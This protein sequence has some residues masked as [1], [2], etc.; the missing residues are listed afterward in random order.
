MKTGTVPRI[1][2]NTIDY[3]EL[4]AQ[5]SDDPPAHFSFSSS[6]RYT[7]PQLPCHITYT[8]EHT[9]EIIRQGID[10]SPLY[11]GIIEGIGARYCPSIEDKV[12]RF[13]EKTRHQI[14]LEP[15]GLDTTEVYPNGIPTSLPLST[16][17]AMIQSIKGLESARIIRP[18]YAIEYDYV[19]PLELLPSLATKKFEGLYLAGQINGTSGY[20]EAAAQGL[21]AAINAVRY[22]QGKDPLILDRSEAYI[23]V[24]IDD[25]VTRGTKEPYRLFT[26][27]AEYRLLLR[28]DNAD[29]RLCQKGYDIGLLDEGKFRIFQQKMHAIAAGIALLNDHHAKPSAEINAA[30]ESLGSN[31]SRQKLSLADL[32]RRPELDLKKIAQ[33][34]LGEELQAQLAE[35]SNSKVADEVQLEIKFQGYI[36]RQREQVDRFKKMEA[37]KLPEDLDYA[38]MSGLSNEVVEKLSTVKPLS[39]GQASRI[40][41]ITPAAISVLQ[42]HLRRLKG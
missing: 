37:V 15:E 25:L 16:Q 14:F 38:S 39:L 2:A 22:V 41:G 11:A 24:L 19:D 20:E 26:S 40:S 33:L 32:L 42:V 6:G 30:L 4:E 17:K 31:T 5:H 23:G 7:L 10:Q 1:D 29:T 8:N 34:P 35:L 36:D 13:P 9:H 28:E 12:M 21:M 3:S 27:R 18:G